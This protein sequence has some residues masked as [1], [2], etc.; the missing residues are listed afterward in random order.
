MFSLQTREL[1]KVQTH[2]MKRSQLF[3]VHTPFTY[4]IQVH[5][6]INCLWYLPIH[7]DFKEYKY[8]VD[9][10][11]LTFGDGAC[12]NYYSHTSKMMNGMHEN[13]R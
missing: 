3:V 7:I 4:K 1:A 2:F 8:V 6:L 12:F 5:I 11:W 9:I 10:D 13:A